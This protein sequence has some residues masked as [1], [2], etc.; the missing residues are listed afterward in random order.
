MKVTLKEKAY[1]KIKKAILEG[2]FKPGDFLSER[3]LVEQLEISR[4]PIRSALERLEAEGFIKQSPK[5]GIVVEIISLDKAMDIYDLRVA[6][7]THVAKSLARKKIDDENRLA[8]EKILMEQ[9]MYMEKGDFDHFS[10]KDFEFHRKLAE[11]Y[12]NREIIQILDQIREKLTLIAINV[13]RKQEARIQTAYE[14]HVRIFDFILAGKDKEAADEV[15]EHF[16]R[17]QNILIT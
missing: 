5:Q 14:E 7:E 10:D 2:R 15:R 17:G 16:V 1:Q 11:I 3:M 6:V 8:V 12:G 4:T 9:K 13:M